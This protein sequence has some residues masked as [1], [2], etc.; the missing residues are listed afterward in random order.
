MSITL[1]L[2]SYNIYISNNSITSIF[3]T[4]VSMLTVKLRPETL[5]VLATVLTVVEI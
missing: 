4:I 1:I 3:D 5:F 2:T